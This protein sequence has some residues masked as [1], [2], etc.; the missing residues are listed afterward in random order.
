MDETST[1]TPTSRPGNEDP[2]DQWDTLNAMLVRS[3]SA[4]RGYVPVPNIFVQ[5]PRGEVAPDDDRGSLLAQL[6]K[7]S[8]LRGL[9]TYLL[10]NALIT[11]GD[12]PDGWSTSYPLQT[13]AR[14]VGVTESASGA[15][16]GSAM[17]KVFKRLQGHDLIRRTRHGKDRSV[18]IT[19]LRPDGSGDAYSRNSRAESDRYF[20][21]PIALW[22]RD[23]NWLG[24]LSLPALAMLL[25]LLHEKPGW[26]ELPAERF[27]QWYGWSA[28]TTS[29]GLEALEAHGI[30]EMHGH[31]R[32]APLAPD[33]RTWVNAYR[34]TGDFSRDSS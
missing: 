8:D 25:V 2:A 9:H 18:R 12:G 23:A 24:K 17:S 4:A 29:R 28:D 30:V 19:L 7:R 32:A 14:A 10:A 21:V 26:V 34:L 13:W 31:Y 22:D 15:S 1:A 20:K 33:G 16:V 27:P 6:V 11:S 3:K 5:K